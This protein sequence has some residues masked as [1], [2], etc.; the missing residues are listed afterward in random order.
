M[1]LKDKVALI[2]GGGSGI[3]EATALRFAQEGA[4][5]VINDVNEENANK[6]A[7]AI[8]AK[9][10][11]VLICIADVT[12]KSDVD[13]MFK[14]VLERFGRLDVLVN[15]AGINKD[16]MAK[17]MSEEEWDDVISINLKGTFLC[18]QAALAPMIAQKSGRIINT[19]SIGALGNIGQTN[20][21]ASKMG[22]IGLTKSLALECAR[23]NITVNCIAPGAT[24][25]PMFAK[26]PPEIAQK[27][28]E[29]VPLDRFGDPSE[30]ANAHLF[31]AS[32]ESS[33]ITG[34]T[35]FVDGGMSVG[36]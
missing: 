6:V 7:E 11:E 33:F 12:K 5:I 30:I 16:R 26:L 22:V 1:R 10:S 3:G 17:K 20:Y 24:F 23:Y 18:A 15:N 36:F 27:I 25:T 19:A 2:T 32:D 9:G 21:S 35:I 28:K 13:N 8:K 4:K 29:K 34:Q 14:Q 31:L